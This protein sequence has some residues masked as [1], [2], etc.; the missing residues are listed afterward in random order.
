MIEQDHGGEPPNGFATSFS[1]CPVEASLGV[2]GRKWSLIIIRNIAIYH[3]Q[4]F[5]EMLR[6]TP[7]LTRRVLSIRLSELSEEGIIENASSGNHSEWVLTDKGRDVIPILVAFLNYGV[8]WHAED[9]FPDKKP[10][11]LSEVLNKDYIEEVV[12]MIL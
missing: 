4:R 1:S 3:K 7:G 12:D 9:V 5:N 10:R 11:V 2:L 6:F 8:K